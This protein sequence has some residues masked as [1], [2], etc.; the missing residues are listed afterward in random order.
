MK[1]NHENTSE[2]LLIK[3]NFKSK[4]GNRVTRIDSP[5]VEGTIISL[6]GGQARV[7]WSQH[8]SQLV[9]VE[10]LMRAG[11]TPRGESK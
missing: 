4:V 6:H 5:E 1:T 7:Y 9:D 11:K 10:A 8:F 3:Q 2:L